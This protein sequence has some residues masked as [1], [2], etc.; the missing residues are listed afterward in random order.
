VTLE[1]L[2]RKR[3]KIESYY[4][5]EG[6]LRRELYRQHLKFFNAGNEWR[7]RLFLAANRVGKTEGVGAF[8]SS[9][10]LTGRYPAWWTGRRFTRPI[11]AWAAGDTGKTVKEILQ[12]KLL[13][14]PGSIGTGMIPGDLIM[15][16]T[17]KGSVPDAIENAYI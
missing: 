2:R 12:D 15:R 11:K 4:P 14:P 5:D 9:C 6:P 10:H 13:G 16:T 1:L 7:E 8:E 17:A 3:N